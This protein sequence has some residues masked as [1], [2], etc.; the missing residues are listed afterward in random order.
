MPPHTP[1]ICGLRLSEPHMA[2]LQALE[3]EASQQHGRASH[4][5]RQITC[6][7]SSCIYVSQLGTSI[8]RGVISCETR[9]TEPL[10]IRPLMP[11]SFGLD[12][13]AGGLARGGFPAGG[14]RAFIL[15]VRLPG[16][17]SR[18]LGHHQGLHTC[19]AIDLGL[20]PKIVTADDSHSPG[21]RSFE[22]AGGLQVLG[23]DLP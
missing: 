4:L 15:L 19:G 3:Y 20:T 14:V 9:S 17:R 18:N 1:S 13:A 21:S 7:G 11:Y 12:G 8:S 23:V 2:V 16:P 6:H 10:Y 22:P 5:W